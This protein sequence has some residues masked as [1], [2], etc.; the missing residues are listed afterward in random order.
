MRTGVKVADIMTRK[1]V[2]CTSNISVYDAVKK[3]LGNNVGSLIVVQK[4]ELIGIITEKD[5]IKKVLLKRKDPKKVKV[6]EVMT[7]NP[8]VISS[9]KDI[10]EAAR[11]MVEKDV[12]RL[13]VCDNNKLLGLITEK[14]LLKIEPGILDILYEKVHLREEMRKYSAVNTKTEGVCE[15]CGNFSDSLEEL[16]GSTICP[17]CKDEIYG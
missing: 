17:E 8:V 3:M 6:E 1:P 15:I 11:L 2:S 14:D 4:E 5:L 10:T 9:D 7:I 13:P 12:R 16:D